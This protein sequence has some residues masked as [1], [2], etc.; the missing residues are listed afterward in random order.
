MHH[1]SCEVEACLDSEEDP[2]SLN[3]KKFLE[4]DLIKSA[5]NALG[6]LQEYEA[7]RD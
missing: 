7:S 2:V 3:K 5:K 1:H 4:V 6:G